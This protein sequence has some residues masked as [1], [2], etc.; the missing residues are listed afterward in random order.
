MTAMEVDD[1]VMTKTEFAWQKL[2]R[3][4]HLLD[5]EEAVALLKDC[6][7]DG[8]EDGEAMW[9]L[10]ICKE[11]GI[12]TEQDIAEAER[13]YKLSRERGNLTGLVLES[14]SEYGRGGLMMLM[15]CLL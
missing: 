2:V 7:K 15:H 3:S 10:G 1:E 11:Y 4:R 14:K 8:D 5:T 6:V 13:L 9:I 12:G